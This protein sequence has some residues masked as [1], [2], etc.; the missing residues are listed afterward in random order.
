MRKLIF[1]LIVLIVSC[2][3]AMLEYKWDCGCDWEHEY[4]PI[5]TITPNSPFSW[6]N[7]IPVL[8]T[9]TST[10]KQM[11]ALDMERIFREDMENDMRGM[12]PRFGYKHSVHYT[13]ENSG[14]WIELPD[15]SRLWRLTISSPGALIVLSL[16]EVL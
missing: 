3:D 10:H 11:M 9:S 4:E 2:N 5:I 16:E 13:V 7:E 12:P 15:G 8:R 1:I 14:E 6:R